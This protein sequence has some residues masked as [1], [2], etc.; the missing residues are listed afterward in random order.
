MNGITVLGLGAMG[1]ALAT[2]LAGAG[3]EVSVWNRSR[4]RSDALVA[5]GARRAE[6]V[7]DALSR[8]ELCLICV[9][10]YAAV[11][12]ILTQASSELR[13]RTIV[14]LT[15]GTPAD[16]RE[17]SSWTTKLGARYLDGAILVTPELVGREA[18]S[19]LYCGDAG[20]FS[21]HAATLSVLGKAIYLGEEPTLAAVREL[22]FLSA[23]FGMF[24]GY[25]QAAALLRSQGE[26][27]TEVTPAIVALLAEMSAL[28]PE[29][30]AQIDS[31]VY[32]APS[33]NNRMMQRALA[34]V[35][36]GSEQQGVGSE[37]VR[38]IHALFERAVEAGLG[39][40]DISA[41]VPLLE[42]PE[43]VHSTS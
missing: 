34:N 9:L 1:S 38:P 22:A 10:D 20:A 28:L 12:E 25:L 23:M 37:L 26:R 13:G 39:D 40:L 4:A 36:G 11:R 18:S 8:S 21:E 3:H 16:A 29:T 42:V 30:A 17:L 2:T 14:N 33:S 24:A 15:N 27:V 6:T 19:V 7:P 5:R 43:S 41:L 35:V 32:P 31:G